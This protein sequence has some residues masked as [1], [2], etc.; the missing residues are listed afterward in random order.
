MDHR[1]QSQRELF[2]WKAAH[3]K[4]LIREVLLVEPYFHK[5]QTKERGEAWKL[6]TQNLKALEA[7]KF[8]VS[9]RAVRDRFAKLMKNFK[10]NEREEARAS[11]IDGVDYDEIY[12][13]LTDI[14]LRMEEAKSLQEEKNERQQSKENV[15]RRNAEEMRRRA[16][17][18]LAETR[19]R[20]E[21]EEECETPKRKRKSNAALSLV[22][23]GL[24]LKRQREERDD[25]WRNEELEERRIARKAQQELMENQQTFLANMQMNQQQF[26]L[27]MQQQHVQALTA[28]TGFLNN[29][30]DK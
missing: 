14:D 4:C 6:I 13:G 23:E 18:S 27:Q 29:L 7:P 19:K 25:K 5:Q 24:K 9:V 8:R 28:I 1:N 12:R 17:E 21:G 15:D 16:T 20:N 3:D 26:M 11:G 10:E 30:K 22:E 2:I